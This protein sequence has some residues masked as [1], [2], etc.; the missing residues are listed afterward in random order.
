MSYQDT[1][2]LPK[3]AFK[4]KADLPKK[5]PEILKFWQKL[6]IYDTLR[7]EKKG[8]PKYILHDGPPYANGDIHMGHA[9]NKILKDIIVKYKSMKGFDAPYVPGWDCHGL[10][11]EYKVLAETP[12]SD[13][14]SKMEIRKVC[15][16]YANHFIQVQ[17]EQFKRLGILGDW[18]N[19]YLTLSND[20]SASVIEVFKKLVE[21]GYIYKSKKPVYWCST[22]KTALAEAEVEYKDVSSPSIYVKFP[23]KPTPKWE[24]LSSKISTFNSQSFPTSILIW[25]TTPWTLPAN[26]AIALNPQFEYALIKLRSETLIMAK[27]LV[28]STLNTAGKNEYEEL[29]TF[30]GDELEMVICQHPFMDRESLVVLGSHVTR[31]QGTGCVHTAPGHGLDDYEVGF[32]YNLPVIIPVDD[33]GRFTNEVEEFAG[34]Y[35]FEA[36]KPIIE[37]IDSLGKLF[38]QETIT[39]SYPHCWRCKN[40]IIFRA[41]DQWFINLKAEDL[42]QRTLNTIKDVNWIPAWGEERFYNTVKY[43]G[44]WCISRQRSWG[45]PIPAFCCTKCNYSLLDLEAIEL[46]ENQIQNYGTNAWFEKDIDTFLPKGRKC[47]KCGNEEFKKEEDIID[48]WFESGISYYAVLKKWDELTFPADLYLEGSDQHRGWFQSAILTSMATDGIPPY[49]AVLTHGFMLDESGKAMSKSL[50]NVVSPLEIID[51]YGADILRLWVISEDYRTDVRLGEEILARMGESY[52]KIRNTFRFMLGNLYDFNPTLDKIPYQD[53]MRIDKWVLHRLTQLIQKIID[54]YEKFEFH[55]IYHLLL[56][57][58]STFLSAL[59]LD[60]LKDRLYTFKADSKERRSAQ[61]VIYEVTTSLTRLMA[62]ILSFT[63][64]EIWQN[65]NNME[66]KKPSVLLSSLPIPN[67]KYLDESLD[68]QWQEILE[69]REK[70]SKALEQSREK[71]LI[72]SSLEAQVILTYPQEKEK[73]IREYNSELKFIFIVSDVELI[74]GEV[75]KV[76]IKKAKGSKCS[77]CWNY[78]EIVGTNPEHPTLCERCIK[79]VK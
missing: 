39:H 59:Y 34:L 7:K 66:D 54:S 14:L 51:K 58:C 33:D 3:T 41:T 42:Q 40:P 2:N 72:G 67:P 1:L 25:T 32:K 47:P 18:E 5:E 70:V 75:L 21:K 9:L 68:S 11:I 23:I 6:N 74:K 69:I 60:I 61:T 12:N 52:R 10:P 20:Y 57:F 13:K 49:K 53:M 26:V 46:T 17:K 27:E 43:R 62:P 29:A 71:G 76:E 22:C 45:V 30:M 35:V 77:R 8:R 37:K 64:E 44:D 4:M 50:G 31:D 16:D 78:S 55:M 48:V 38:H 63:A 79:I 65:L 56:N 24:T 28:E 19:P 15:R 36:N 73:V